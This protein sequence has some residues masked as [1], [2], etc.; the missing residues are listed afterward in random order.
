MLRGSS[1]PDAG[2]VV[3]AV[4][5]DMRR[6]YELSWELLAAMGKLKD[7]TGA[8]RHEDLDWEL[9]A[10]WFGA[11]RIRHVVLVDAQWLTSRLLAEVIGLAAVSAVHL[12][13]VAQQP[14]EDSFVDAV[15]RWPVTPGGDAELAAHIAAARRSNEAEVDSEFPAVPDDNYPTF[16]AEARRWLS[17]GAFEVVDARY[18]SSFATASKAIDDLVE[19]QQMGEDGLLGHVRSELWACRSVAE[20]KTALRAIQAAAHRA[21]WLVSVD[22][23][24]LLVTAET[25]AQGAVH[26][27]STWR[28][29]RAYREP[30]RGAACAFAALEVSTETMRTV[31][32]QDISAEGD[33]ATVL[34]QGGHEALGVP[35]GADLY[36]RAQVIHRRNQGARDSDL[37]FATEDEQM[38]PRYLANAI[39]CPLTEVGVPLMSRNVD[40]AEVTSTHWAQRWGLAVQKL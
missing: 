39:R 36:L 35:R 37:L 10:A 31:A 11:H 25:V 8:G 18:R 20:M 26:S 29:L 16:R 7:V 3:A 32:L 2:M 38:L 17:P 33:S 9:L 40:W 12:W 1:N 28:R 34:R 22:L 4:P 19:A 27:P 13:L 6:I 24:R 5:P 30:Y 14:I 23:P 21:G 15:G